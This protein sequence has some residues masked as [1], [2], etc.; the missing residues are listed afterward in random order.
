MTQAAAPRMTSTSATAPRERMSRVDTAWLRMDNDVN[1]MMIVGVWLLTPAID[2]ETLC[3]RVED[4]LLRY[5][6]FRQVVVR[7]A[8]DGVLEAVRRHCLAV[9]ELEALPDREGV[10]LAAVRYGE[11]RSDLGDEL[12][13]RRTRLVRIVVELRCGRIL[14]PPRSGDIRDLRVDLGRCPGRA[15]LPDPAL[16]ESAGRA[17]RARK[18]RCDQKACPSHEHRNREP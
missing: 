3:R 12:G 2:Y 5:D 14:E 7:D 17:G 4:K 9:A 18:A 10:L 6:R 15:D 13:A 8:V 16:L 11:L 1:L